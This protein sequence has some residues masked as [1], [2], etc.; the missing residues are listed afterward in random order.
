MKYLASIVICVF[1]LALG[2][3]LG[4]DEIAQKDSQ[5]YSEAEAE[6]SLDQSND[7]SFKKDLESEDKN[8]YLKKKKLTRVQKKSLV[9]KNLKYLIEKAPFSLVK[10]IYQKRQFDLRDAAF[11]DYEKADSNDKEKRD[12]FQKEILA[13]VVP[14]IKRSFFY[15]AEG[16]LKFKGLD[17]PYTVSVSLSN[18]WPGSKKKR[19][20][21]KEAKNFSYLQ[22]IDFDTSK[23][24]FEDDKFI[25]GSGSG[26][27]N[28]VRDSGRVFFKDMI[29]YSKRDT[30]FNDIL[31]ILIEAP[32]RVGEFGALRLFDSSNLKWTEVTD[33]V[34]WKPITEREFKAA[35]KAR[36]GREE[37]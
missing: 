34:D 29:Y 19:S 20:I 7:E 14:A 8:S 30:V 16:L 17:I 21:P 13:S 4:G 5:N 24:G 9:E 36:W 25:A 2:Y 27:Y 37:Y 22:L 3:Y 10:K 11:G 12:D 31:Y 15:R 35:L 26:M 32:G 6:T 23:D 33:R 1:F 18:P 28:V